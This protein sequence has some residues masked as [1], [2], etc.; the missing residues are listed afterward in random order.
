MEKFI[1][2]LKNI[3]QERLISV[4]MYGSKVKYSQELVKTDMNVMVIVKNLSGN[5]IRACSEIVNKWMKAKNPI[6]VFMEREE[7]FHSSDVY[8]M[9][10]ADIKAEHRILYGE[11]LI[12]DLNVDPDNI[13]FQCEQETKNLLMRFR[14]FYLENAHS[15]K[16]LKDSFV[17]L[18]KTCNAIFKA[19]LR[20]KFCYFCLTAEFEM[21][22]IIHDIFAAVLLAAGIPATAAAGNPVQEHIEAAADGTVLG[23]AGFGMLAVT[24]GGDTLAAYDFRRA[25]VPASNMKLITTGA[26]LHR[27]G[28]DYR[29]KT[30]IGYSGTIKDGFSSMC[31]ISLSA[32]LLIL[33]KYASSLPFC[34]GFP[35]SGHLPSTT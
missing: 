22:T 35:Q 14:Q 3:L 9:E 31:F 21:K 29:Y 12:S 30:G 19:I 17:P 16:R 4:F 23:N 32:Y 33:K 7:W 26:A 5:D 27:L 11:D 10:Y 28:A 20:V 15:P 2:N 6:P 13:R 1:D 34:T 24:S 8:A 18:A 25:M